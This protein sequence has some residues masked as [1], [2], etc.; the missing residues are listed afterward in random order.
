VNDTL[1]HFAGDQILEEASARIRS[2]L[3]DEDI[4]ARFG[5]DEFCVLLEDFDTVEDVLIPAQR[6]TEA[7]GQKFLINGQERK[8]GASIGITST[9]Q[10]GDRDSSAMLGDADLAMYQA[11]SAGRG[12]FMWFSPE[13]REKV[14]KSIG[15]ENEFER[16]LENGEFELYYQPQVDVKGGD[17]IGLEALIRWNH[18]IQGFMS[19]AEF[20][21]E[22]ESSKFMEP[23]GRWVIKEACRQLSEWQKNNHQLPRVSV[24]VSPSQFDDESFPDFVSQALDAHSI[25]AKCLGIE[26]TETLF[27]K[28]TNC[29]E[30]NMQRINRMGCKISLDDFGTGY[31]SL[32]YL[33][34]FPVDVIKI[35]Q[36]FIRGLLSNPQYRVLISSVI[37]M[38]EGFNDMKVVAEG[39]EEESQLETLKELGCD[40][41]QGYLYSKPVPASA[42]EPMLAD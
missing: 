12:R 23:V 6:I 25:E 40:A 9:L 37:G 19:P 17:L 15:M 26:I 1:G 16:A 10:L 8:L 18:P 27:M 4:L 7:L 3:R 31:S 13:M 33:I 38:A 41:Y 22:L 24:N 32:S 14:Q 42:I 5:G 20:L 2:C 11:K 35:D 34:R 39:V 36:I 21:P 30:K 28:H 29:I